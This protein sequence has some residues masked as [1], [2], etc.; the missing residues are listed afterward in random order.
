MN[1]KSKQV[2]LSF[3]WNR[4]NT[5]WVIRPNLTFTESFV[6]LL[7]SR[8]T[9]DLSIQCYRKIVSFF[10]FFPSS[11]ISFKMSR[12]FASFSLPFHNFVASLNWKYES[13]FYHG[14]YDWACLTL[15]V[16]LQIDCSWSS[17]GNDPKLWIFQII[18]FDV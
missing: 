13:N 14:V 9:D 6:L 15:H 2:T 4:N 12:C 8:K 7:C 18:F 3:I 1:P 11:Y 5:V 17:I 16:L 10:F